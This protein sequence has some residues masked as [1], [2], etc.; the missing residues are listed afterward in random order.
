MGKEI[1][2][3]DS[4]TDLF[5]VV[6]IMHTQHDLS[7]INGL[8]VNY[9]NVFQIH[10]S[11]DPDFMLNYCT[12]YFDGEKICT[13]NP[14][15]KTEILEQYSSWKNRQD[16]YCFAMAYKPI[17]E[18]YHEF[19]QYH[20]N[21]TQIIHI[22][23]EDDK[24]DVSCTFKT[25]QHGQIF[26]GMIGLRKPPKEGVR[27]WIASMTDDSGI[28]FIYAS[29]KNEQ[30]AKAFGKMI[31]LDTDWNSCISLTEKEVELDESD[32][33]AHLPNGIKRIREHLK[34]TD[35]VPLLVPLFS[36]VDP[37]NARDMIEILQEYGEV[38]MV[39]GS[40]TNYANTPVFCQANTSLVIDPNSQ[41]VDLP[42]FQ[43]NVISRFTHLENPT[44][45]GII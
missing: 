20:S 10:S 43:Q 18:K 5:K 19:I 6:Q 41:E 32:L 34:T 38:V 9:E 40:S 13:L 1:G 37:E 31:G 35:N 11:G 2:F 25:I 42:D 7:K 28:R 29:P 17:D 39:V 3:S 23:D 22:D 36:D 44:N 15:I 12:D 45:R 33:K 14:Q 4:V 27:E 21:P 16:L 24:D 26:L 8:I 30:T